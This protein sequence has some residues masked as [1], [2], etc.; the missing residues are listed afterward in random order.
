MHPNS[1][2][3]LNDFSTYTWIYITIIICA[4]AS[5]ALEVSQILET[6]NILNQ[7]KEAFENKD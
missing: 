7:L 2:D 6:I 5:F 1:C 4:S 3:T